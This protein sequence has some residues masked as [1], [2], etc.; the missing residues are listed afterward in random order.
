MDADA[1]AV[2]GAFNFPPRRAKC[3]MTTAEERQAK[4]EAE[5]MKRLSA[6]LRANLQMRKAQTRA[7][8]AGDEDARTGLPAAKTAAENPD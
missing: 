4:R 3:T 5:K 7:R 8:R 1:Q 6:Q 2:I